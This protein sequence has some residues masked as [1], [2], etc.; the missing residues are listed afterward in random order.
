MMP[1]TPLKELYNLRRYIQHLILECEYDYD[2]DDL[3]NPLHEDNWLFQ[4]RKFMK[5][6]IYNGHAMI[7]KLVDKSAVRPI[8]KV[9]PNH[10]LDT[11]ERESGTPTGSSEGSISGTPTGS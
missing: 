5:S 8:T 1:T 11:D 9:N 4:S 6:V 10:K 7:H 3:D 2:D